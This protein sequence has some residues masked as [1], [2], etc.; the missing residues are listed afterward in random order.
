M[1]DTL[2][3]LALF[4][5]DFAD[6]TNEVLNPSQMFI[7]RNDGLCDA[8]LLP[9]RDILINANALKSCSTYSME[10]INAIEACKAIS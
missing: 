9:S 7:S 8:D 2:N 4:N 5:K 1:G 3:I 10:E 6:I